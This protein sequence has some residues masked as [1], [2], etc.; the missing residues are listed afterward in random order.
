MAKPK[1]EPVAKP[2]AAPATAKAKA[3]TAEPKPRTRKPRA[4]TGKPA[5]AARNRTAPEAATAPQSPAAAST[6]SAPSAGPASSP[7]S[8]TSTLAEP[9]PGYSGL[10]MASLRARLRGKSADQI[11]SLIEY[12]RKTSDRDDIVQMYA[13]RLAK[14]EAGE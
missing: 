9:L 1:A 14:L 4:A 13:K 2:K 7:A 3:A 5:D 11:R 8:A 10:T 6:P 12:E